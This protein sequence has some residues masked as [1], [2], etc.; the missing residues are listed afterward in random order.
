MI[1]SSRVYVVGNG[2]A[3]LHQPLFALEHPAA[4]AVAQAFVVP[5]EPS[6]PVFGDGTTAAVQF[7]STEALLTAAAAVGLWVTE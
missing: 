3:V 4:W 2:R 6:D 1:T 5:L 7:T